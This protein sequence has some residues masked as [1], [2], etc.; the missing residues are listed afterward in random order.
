MRDALRRAVSKETTDDEGRKVKRAEIIAERLVR[1]AC[2]GDLAAIR[3]VFDRTDGKAVQ[4][5]EH[6]GIV[7]QYVARMPSVCTS[8]DEWLE[9]YA[10]KAS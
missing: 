4:A 8:A 5:L 1:Q 2:A 6:S 9:K 3:E 10:P 7:S